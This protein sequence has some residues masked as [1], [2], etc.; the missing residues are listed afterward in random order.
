M[1]SSD[2]LISCTFCL[3]GVIAVFLVLLKEL[4]GPKSRSPRETRRR[5]WDGM[6]SKQYDYVIPE[7]YNSKILPTETRRT[8]LKDVYYYTK[9]DGYLLT[10]HEFRFLKLLKLVLEER[11][12]LI[13]CKV[14]LGDLVYA[15][16]TKRGWGFGHNQISRKH[17]DYAICNATNS[18]ILLVIELDDS[19]HYAYDRR[20]RDEFVDSVLNDARIP[21]THVKAR[22]NYNVQEIKNMILPN[23]PA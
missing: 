3:I 4:L 20:M 6:N 14:R 16:G 7:A 23:I 15:K 21:I 12:V 9:N 17:V 2:T 18:K 22:N 19:S 13:F 8:V 10:E 5:G 1:K 11:K